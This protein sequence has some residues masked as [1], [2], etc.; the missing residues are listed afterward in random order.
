MGTT[1]PILYL[2][3]APIWGGAEAVLVTL[4]HNLNRQQFQP[5]VATAPD[6]SLAQ[7][8]ATD[9]VPVLPVPFDNLNQAGWRLPFNLARSI[10]AVIRLIRQ[11]HIALIHTNTVRAHIVGSLAGWL[12]RTPVIWTLH[13]NTFPFRLVRWLAPIPSHV[14]TVSTWLADTYQPCGLSGRCSVIPNGLALITDEKQS[15]SIRTELDI[16]TNA[17]I[18]L[19]VGRLIAGKAPDLFITAAESATFQHPDTHFILVGGPDDGE[20]SDH[21]YLKQL[22]QVIAGTSLG[23]RLHA[24]GPRQD[25]SRFYR[26]A[27][28]MVYNAVQPEGLPTVLLEAMAY[29]KPVIA[30]AIGGA[31]EIVQDGY[32]GILTPPNNVTALADAMDTLLSSPSDQETMGQAGLKRLTESFT[33]SQ[34]VQK[35]TKIYLAI[36]QGVQP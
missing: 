16:P 25:V 4:L 12:T 30:S 36:L 8:L 14:I 15:P 35:T 20:A 17:P 24:V 13:D 9:N 18:V 22:T 3:H 28:I 23:I 11:H 2:D 33:V 34:Q 27:N 31:L 32:T 10:T 19:N 21:A 29:A 6:S 26:A 7:R 5:F 1:F